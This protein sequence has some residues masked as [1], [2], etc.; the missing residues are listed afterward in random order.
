MFGFV[1]SPKAVADPPTPAYDFLPAYLR[2]QHAPPSP[3]PRVVLYG[4][5]ALLSALS[6]WA[7]F[8]HLDIVATADGKLVPRTYLK[9]VQPA[10]GGVVRE[11]LVEEGATVVAGQP[12][13][14]LDTSLSAAD[15]R[16]LRNELAART[17]QLRRIDA[18][19]IDG[20]ISRLP[21]ELDDAYARV[22]AQ[23]H[24]NRQAY[25]DSL[26][27]E[28]AT[29]E[30]IAK[31]LAAA[32]EVQGK[33]QRT[34]PIYRTMA[35]RFGMLKQE[36]FVSELFHLEKERD[37][38][39]KE[40]DLRAQ[41]FT[42]ESL[43]ASLEQARQRLSQVTSNYRQQLHG[44]RAQADAQAKKVTE[45]LA[46]QHYRNALVELSAPQAGIVKDIAAHTVGTVVSPGSILLTMVPLG[47]ELQ[48][49]VMVKNLDAG[50]VRRG[51][52][53]RVKVVAYPFQ[54]YGMI[55][56]EVIRVSADSSE[57]GTGKAEEIDA[58]GKATSQSM[59]RAR[60]ALPGQR[61]RV[62]S[63]ELSLISGMQ[64]SAEIK[65]GERT[66]LEYLLAPVQKAWHEAGR[67]R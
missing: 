45:D 26:A 1:R 15:T 48:A 64:V 5:T 16:A 41:D 18:E 39:E 34:V 53:A 13:M 28:R 7:V 67:E 27:Q 52:P 32:L 50:F 47:D 11:I 29:T 12:L 3:L 46:K 40:Q 60:I 14:R 43:R 23:F 31:E 58:E 22:E 21:D 61:M 55:D 38:I 57:T 10:D 17:L 42:V 24:A 33:L 63:A 6:A 66:V 49:D 35:E 54:K 62:A 4:L 44:E 56:G 59:Y 20:A 19:L 37:R 36:G 51:Q 65:L 9:I 30:R 2:V 25:D 8:G